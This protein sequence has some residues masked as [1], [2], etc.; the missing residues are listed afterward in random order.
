LERCTDGGGCLVFAC[1]TGKSSSWWWFLLLEGSTR[2]VSMIQM[3]VRIVTVISAITFTF[4]LPS[5]Y[6]TS[7]G[8]GE[9]NM[10]SLW[11]LEWRCSLA[12]WGPS[13]ICCS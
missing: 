11:K 13:V 12:G 3:L 8:T 10:H 1:S 6:C 7:L 9:L 2:H 5:L 4:L